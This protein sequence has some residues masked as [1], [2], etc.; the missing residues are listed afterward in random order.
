MEVDVNKRPLIEFK[1]L[2]CVQ[3][4]ELPADLAIERERCEIGIKGENEAS[5]EDEEDV[6]QPEC[7]ILIEDICF[8]TCTNEIL[9]IVFKAGRQEKSNNNNKFSLSMHEVEE[10]KKGSLLKMDFLSLL[11]VEM[12]DARDTLLSL[13]YHSS[14][15]IYFFMMTQEHQVE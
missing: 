7:K 4:L 14:G 15:M 12:Q 9:E 2:M 5:H 10:F 8:H 11:I 1:N 13:F 3:S 6:Y